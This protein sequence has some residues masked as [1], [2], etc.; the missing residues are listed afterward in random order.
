M[1]VREEATTGEPAWV[2]MIEVEPVEDVQ[3]GVGN[4]NSPFIRFADPVSDKVSV[5]RGQAASVALYAAGATAVSTSWCSQA[6]AEQSSGE[7]IAAASADPEVEAQQFDARVECLRYARD[8]AW[9][10]ARMACA[11]AVKDHP[12]DMELRVCH[13]EA[14]IEMMEPCLGIS[15]LLLTPSTP[16]ADELLGQFPECDTQELCTVVA[17]CV[18]RSDTQSADG[19]PAGE[20]ETRGH[21]NPPTNVAP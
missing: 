16:R 8:E 2:F 14:L 5:F 4:R 7:S 12:D 17:P 10:Q 11:L 1:L 9:G 20:R 13:G 15:E 3:C 19:Q 21:R 6:S 18:L